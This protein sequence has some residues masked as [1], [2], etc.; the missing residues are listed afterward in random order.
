M[1]PEYQY[2]DLASR[3]LREGTLQANRTSQKALTIDGAMMQFDLDFGFP[4]LTTKTVYYKQAFA[5]LIGFL[6][7][8]DNA[9]D[10]ADLGCKWWFKDANEN[11]QWLASPH[12]KGENDL[13][14]VYG[15][16]WRKWR[17]TPGFYPSKLREGIEATYLEKGN[18]SGST[19]HPL[20]KTWE[21]MMARC[22]DRN[23]PSYP[24][25]GARGVTVCSRWLEFKAFA[26]DAETLPGW[27]LKK[28][29]PEAFA[30]QLDKD[31]RG[32][33][34]YY[35]PESCTWVSC[36]D[37]QNQKVMYRSYVVEKDGVEYAF[38]NIS[39]FCKA[40]GIEGKN[41]SDLWTGNK[42]AKVRS[43]FTLVRVDDIKKEEPCI[44][45]VQVALDLIR[46]ANKTGVASRRIIINAWRP[47]EFDQMA[48]PPCHVA[49]EFMVNVEKGELNMSMWQRSCDLFLGVPMNIAT[50]ALM[51]TLFAAATG[52]K[53]GRFTH[54]LSDVHIYENHIEQMKEQVQRTPRPFPHVA[55]I[56]KSWATD[57]DAD[58]MAAVHPDNI[59]VSGYHPHEPIKGEMVT[60]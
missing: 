49:Y 45:Q 51:L 54:F 13:G 18:G 27:E 15:V 47:D 32:D 31:V 16:N 22:Y 11:T 43:G 5:E 21:G 12:R 39:D 37:N 8:L 2:L 6:R 44:D 58:Q 42:N 59:I 25:Y 10:F 55:I 41:F 29:N 7:G 4:L 1:H 34:F 33:G 50:S 56:S 46:A 28:N 17:V 52:M 26:E 14:R 3:V 38:S 60:G 48:L 19:K 53:P 35:S 57:W 23:S 24:L 30:V 40:H 9:Q 20:G 36:K